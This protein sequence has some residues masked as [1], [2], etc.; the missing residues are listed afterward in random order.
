MLGRIPQ[1]SRYAS[2]T[3]TRLQDS[4]GHYNLSVL[5]N[6]KATPNV[7]FSLYVWR[8]GDRPDLVAAQKLGDS[9]LWW[10]IF[11]INPEII[12]PLGIPPGSIVR[13]P[14]QPVM[15]QGTLNQ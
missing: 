14:A 7:I 3:L 11:D 10:A 9:R 15:G 6:V 8:E 12:Y 2:G 1:R 4:K 5:R 13:I